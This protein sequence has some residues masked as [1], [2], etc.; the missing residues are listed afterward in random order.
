MSS[1]WTGRFSEPPGLVSGSNPV[2]VA[3]RRGRRRSRSARSL[4]LTPVHTGLEIL[5][6]G[7]IG[8][9]VAVG[10]WLLG[11]NRPFS[12]GPALMLL[13]GTGL[14]LA[15]VLWRYPA[16][17]WP[18]PPPVL[19]PWLVFLAYVS[20]RAW[21]G[22][23]YDAAL[24]VARFSGL[25]LMYVA[26]C[27]W[28][29]RGDRWKW[30]LGAILLSAS[31][32]AWYAIILDA[33]G[34]NMILWFMERPEDYGMR[35]S[36][37]F[38]CPNHFAQMLGLVLPISLV[39]ALRRGSGLPLRLLGGYTFLVC[40]YPLLL[41]QS[42][43]GWLGAAAGTGASLW[44]LASRKGWRASVTSAA[45]LVAVFCGT[46]YALW[47]FSDIVRARVEKAMLGDV[48][49][50]LWQDTLDMVRDRPL[51]GFGPGSYR[52]AY[53][54][55]QHALKNYIDPEFAH[56][57]YLHFA[58]ELG[59]IGLVLA[60]IAWAGLFVVLIRRYLRTTRDRDVTLLAGGLGA[61]FGTL[62]HAGF[63][64][65][66]NIYGNAVLIVAVAGLVAGVTAGASDSRTGRTRIRVAGAVALLLGGFTMVMG[67]RMLGVTRALD[68]ANELSGSLD[69][70]ESERWLARA[71][72]W[73]GSNW[74]VDLQEA[75]Y[76][77]KRSVWNR[78]PESREA[79]LQRAE[80]LYRRVLDA[81]PWDVQ[82]AY[83]LTGIDWVRG[84]TDAVLAARLELAERRPYDAFLQAEAGEML[85]WMGRTAEAAPYLEKAWAL[86]RD[87]AYLDR[88]RELREKAARQRRSG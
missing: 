59:V 4:P 82:A 8:L 78:L 32:M 36:G 50:I 5:A 88:W 57:E 19:I 81:N 30:L 53:H 18:S 39:L 68:R 45:L 49:L 62:V 65:Q 80:M 86:S 63:D 10:P 58:A 42:R 69:Y 11:L 40:L 66:F 37:G 1:W 2:P 83:G 48:R 26:V 87:P 60:G 12:L 34:S 38:V 52:F 41:A 20:V 73:Y 25:L 54:D 56:N 77:R 71:R 6:L 76:L 14:I 79:Q 64:F 47:S 84:R 24:Q 9:V 70:A 51:A 22:I 27:L 85:E 74:R 43:A 16:E 61:L 3:G 55:Y 35:A 13:G 28:A 31:I 15:M 7:L 46:G 75:D 67:L 21:W 44:L 17:A 29:P 33:R 23:P 72:A